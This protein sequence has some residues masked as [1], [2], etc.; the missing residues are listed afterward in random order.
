MQIV[1]R[2]DAIK[3]ALENMQNKDVLVLA[4][5]GGEK[6]IA[7]GDELICFDEK[8]IVLDFFNDSI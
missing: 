2:S 7:I 1:D 5:K 3:H 6:V 8:Q 4:G